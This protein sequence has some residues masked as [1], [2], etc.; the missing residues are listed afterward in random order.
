MV[1]KAAIELFHIHGIDN[2][3]VFPIS[4]LNTPDIQIYKVKK[5]ACMA[6]KGKGVHSGIRIIYAYHHKTSTVVFIEIY[7]KG[8]KANE[9]RAR[10]EEYLENN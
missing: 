4:G 6:L 7:Y 1:K 10:A 3:S 8:D 9:N 5:V 2:A